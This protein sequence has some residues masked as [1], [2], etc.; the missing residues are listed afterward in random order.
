MERRKVSVKRLFTRHLI[1]LPAIPLL[2]AVGLALFA[3]HEL[4]QAERMD[5]HGAEAVAQVIDRDIRTRRDSEG[6]TTTEYRIEYRFQPSSGDP[7]T[8]RRTVS[9]P[10]YEAQPPG[11]ELPVRYLVHDPG[12]NVIDPGQAR[13][14]GRL[15]SLIALPFALAGLV[16][17][18]LIGRRKLTLL[19]AAWY[20]EVRQARVEEVEATN[21][22]VNGRTQY[23]LRWHD[24]AGQEGRSGARDY[25]DLPA[26][27]SVIVI[28]VDPRSGRGWW[29]EDF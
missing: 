5:L 28:Y 9:R 8:T 14:T 10:V 23:R 11:S 1:W 18:V 29:E 16:A 13:R 2:V 20:G 7:I 3:S 24:A 25:N 22:Q 6:R 27:G 15:L 21:L 19:R 12:I 17:T 4:R 26:V